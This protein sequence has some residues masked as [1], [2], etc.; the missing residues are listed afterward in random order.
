M[1]EPSET[2]KQETPDNAITTAEDRMPML[3][4]PEFAPESDVAS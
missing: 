2:D 1:R 4:R 3:S